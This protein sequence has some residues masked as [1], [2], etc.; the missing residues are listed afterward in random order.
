MNINI[1]RPRDG[2]VLQRIAESWRIPDSKVS[3]VPDPEADVNLWVNYALFKTVGK[4]K[5]TRCDIGYFTHYE[6]SGP[7]GPLFCQV[8]KSMD[9][10]IAMCEQTARFLPY[11]KTTVVHSSPHRQFLKK[12]IVLGVV[13][14]EY[15]RKQTK[16]I[17]G[18]RKIPGIEIRC[19]DGKLPFDQLPDFYRSIDYLLVLSELEGG[20]LPVLEALAMGKPVIAP[21]VGWCWDYPVIRYSDTEM[22]T[23]ILKRLIVPG[24]GRFQL[25]SEQITKV[26]NG[27]LTA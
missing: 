2:W 4:F 8:A 3:D 15:P 17:P 13:G 24:D 10:C 19:T 20:P 27:I 18:L 6:K 7:L 23:G 5:K 16:L 14:R 25:E 9:H 26:I 21:D 12:R 11:D 22:L 1:V